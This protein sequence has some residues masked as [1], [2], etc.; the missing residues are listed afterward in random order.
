MGMKSLVIIFNLFF[1]V[2][3]FAYGL[4]GMIF[5]FIGQKID[6]SFTYF[7]NPL[8]DRLFGWAWKRGKR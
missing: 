6:D 5:I 3:M 2:P 8:E 7:I 1:I 4:I